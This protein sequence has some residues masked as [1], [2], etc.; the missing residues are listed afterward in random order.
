MLLKGRLETSFFSR[1]DQRI[2]LVSP[3]QVLKLF[4]G[5][6]L[7]SAITYVSYLIHTYE[8]KVVRSPGTTPP[9]TAP[10]TI[11]PPG[12]TPPGTTPPGTTPP[13]ITPPSGGEPFTGS[14]LF[15]VIISVVGA[16]LLFAFILFAITRALGGF[17]WMTAE[18]RVKDLAYRMYNLEDWIEENKK[19]NE[20]SAKRELK[21]MQGQINRN[22]KLYRRS[23][24]DQLKREDEPRIPGTSLGEG[25][26]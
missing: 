13:T 10:P 19:Q 23:F 26:F 25:E 14:T 12:T 8:P 11:T 5:V 16:A 2:G 20:I 24:S 18:E 3:S 1:L 15:W 17:P 7:I 22:I 4:S 9:G 6:V 21:R